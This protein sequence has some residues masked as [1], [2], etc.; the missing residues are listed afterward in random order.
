[1]SGWR[2]PSSWS[3]WPSSSWRSP[4]CA[5]AVDFPAPLLLIAVGIGAVLRAG[6]ARGAARARDRAARAAAAAALLGRH[7]DLAGRLQRQPAGDPA[8]V[9]RPGRLHDLRH[10]RGWSTRCS[11]TSAGRPRSRSARSSRRPT[12]SP[13]PRSGAG[14]GCHG[15]SSPSSRASRCSTTR[16]PWSRCAR[17]SLPP[18]WRRHGLRG[19]RRLRASPPAAAWRSAWRCSC[20]WRWLRKRVTDPVL[21]TGDLVRGAVRGL[22]RRR[23]GP[24]LRCASPSSS[25]GCCSG[26]RRRSSRPRSRASPSG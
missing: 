8:A 6:R 4:P 13:P 2:S 21:D 23:G 5:D 18:A 22:R 17:R 14:S 3:A 24:R 15:G 9:G 19:R 1:M 20:S 16:P 26:T 7:P 25:P 11:R 12:P 10:R